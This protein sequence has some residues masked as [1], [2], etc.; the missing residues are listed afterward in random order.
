MRYVTALS[1][2]KNIP[3]YSKAVCIWLLYF[4]S[5]INTTCIYHSL[6]IYVS[7]KKHF[8]SFF[9]KWLSKRTHY[10]YKSLQWVA[11]KR[12][13]ML[14]WQ[15]EASK[16]VVCC[17]KFIQWVY[18]DHISQDITMLEAVTNYSTQDWKVK[19]IWTAQRRIKQAQT[20]SLSKNT[21]M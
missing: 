6:L 2:V 17:A 15:E 9:D 1:I 4:S 3:S 16:M 7:V 10:G 21:L 13:K 20:N 18:D 12:H 8:F 19:A 5:S 11:A 14:C